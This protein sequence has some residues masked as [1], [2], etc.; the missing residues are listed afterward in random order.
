MWLRLLGLFQILAG[1][2]LSYFAWHVNSKI[3]EIDDQEEWDDAVYGSG[4]GDLAGYSM[5]FGAGM[6]LVGLCCLVWF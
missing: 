3:Q 5:V 6:I 4:A 2:A 1:L